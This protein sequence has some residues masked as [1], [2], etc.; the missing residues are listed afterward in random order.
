MEFRLAL[1]IRRK[2]DAMIMVARRGFSRRMFGAS[3]CVEAGRK[4][5]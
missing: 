3:G 2:A 5:E 1:G 4:S